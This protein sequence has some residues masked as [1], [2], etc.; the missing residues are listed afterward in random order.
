MTVANLFH[1]GGAGAL[2]LT[3]LNVFIANH[4]ACTWILIL[5]DDLGGLLTRM[6]PTRFLRY[7]FLLTVLDHGLLRNRFAHAHSAAHAAKTT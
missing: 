7:C 2:D 6:I 3:I 4:L 1:V 5:L